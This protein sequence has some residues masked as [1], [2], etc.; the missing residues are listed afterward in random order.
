MKQHTPLIDLRMGVGGDAD[1]DDDAV[2]LA[3]GASPLPFPF[4]AL[5]GV[6]ELSW[7]SHPP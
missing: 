3:A 4:V 1:D 5:L 2:L 6:L 7:G